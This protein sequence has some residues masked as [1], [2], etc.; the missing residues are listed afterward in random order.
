[1]E[2]QVGNVVV[3]SSYSKYKMTVTSI[4]KDK[5]ECKYFKGNKLIVELYFLKDLEIVR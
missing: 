2:F 4:I 1:M 3:L 5:A